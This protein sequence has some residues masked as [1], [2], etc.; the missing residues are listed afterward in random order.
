MYYRC[1]DTDKRNDYCFGELAGRMLIW[2]DNRK[3]Y[4]KLVMREDD[5]FVFRPVKGGKTIR[6]ETPSTT[7]IDYYDLYVCFPN[8]LDEKE[9]EY[10]KAVVKP[11]M[12]YHDL[13]IIKERIMNDF[14]IK[15]II[16]DLRDYSSGL[17]QFPL[18]KDK[19]M[20]QGL[21]ED[22]YYNLKELLC[23]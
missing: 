12:K 11:F 13:E 5:V 9:K 3:M 10:L 6:I 16:I 8:F 20:Y 17:I 22:K 18:F 4:L 7:P 21:E 2:S 14:S 15:I 1:E 19:T 23:L